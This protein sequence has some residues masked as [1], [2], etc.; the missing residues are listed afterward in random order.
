M[1]EPYHTNYSGSYHPDGQQTPQYSVPPPL[2]PAQFPLPPIRDTYQLSIDPH[3]RSVPSPSQNYPEYGRP[4]VRP[5]TGSI[6]SSSRVGDTSHRSSSG[7][8]VI[9]GPQHA[10]YNATIPYQ[11]SVTS[12]T[13]DPQP[14]QAGP[15]YPSATDSPPQATSGQS[16]PVWY[17]SS[18]P[19][20]SDRQSTLF[21][22]RAE[23]PTSYP[24]RPSYPS[25]N[26]S[27]LTAPTASVSFSHSYTYPEHP[28]PSLTA[29][30]QPHPR[31]HSRSRSPQHPDSRS[32]PAL[33]SPN[34]HHPLLPPLLIPEHPAAYEVVSPSDS[35][36]LEGRRG[37]IGPCRDLAPLHALKR[38]RPYRRDPVDD[39]A[40][41]RLRPRSP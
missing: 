21:P 18:I 30:P 39:K 20:C 33:P 27:V 38:S 6:S 19:E 23:L 25:T 35:I 12:S 40:L 8:D 10:S 28:D 15:I 37:S 34:H 3:N 4:D 7:P 41:R 1:Y 16:P 5:S 36:H 17:L 2:P 26:P 31:P 32:S 24:L 9:E 22:S 29:Y 13:H 11:P 14:N